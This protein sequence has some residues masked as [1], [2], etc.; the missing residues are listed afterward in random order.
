V[1]KTGDN[2]ALSMT[3]ISLFHDT[4]DSIAGI[5]TEG[6]TTRLLYTD[7]WTYSDIT[8]QNSQVTLSIKSRYA[9]AWNNYYESILSNEGLVNGQDYNITSSSDTLQ[10]VIDRV[11]EISV[12]HAFVETYIGRAAT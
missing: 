7:S 10:I 11:S 2:V 6:V 12:D 1:E 8:S 4:D 3:L 5:S 9:D